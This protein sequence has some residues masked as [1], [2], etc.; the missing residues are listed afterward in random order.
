[1]DPNSA[2]TTAA[3]R[4]SLAAY[5]A[6]MGDVPT[7]G[8]L[9]VYSIFDGQVTPQAL[10][11]WFKQLGLDEALLPGAARPVDAFERTTTET[12]VSYSL[13]DPE[14][15]RG[16]KRE[17]GEEVATLMVRPVAADSERIVR[18]LVREVRHERAKTLK[19]ETRLAEIVFERDLSKD[20]DPGGGAMRI[21]PDPDAIGRLADNER[22]R[23]LEVISEIEYRYRHRRTYVS[24]DRLRSLVRKYTEGLNAVRVR[25][26]GGVYFVGHQ[27]A[28]TLA[29]LHE[30]V[31][32]FGEGSN[33]A[34][35]PLPDQEEM[36]E[37]VVS[38]WRERAREDLQRLSRDIAAARKSGASQGKIDELLR[39]FR[40]IRATAQE[41]SSLL[42]ETLEE[43]S[44]AMELAELQ[45]KD[46]VTRA[47]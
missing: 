47:D 15:T 4:D 33:F 34:R 27:H 37:M 1:M 14:R 30:L 23:V 35:V 5:E 26:T 10:E 2:D 29:A 16:R 8:Y 45:I 41:H 13:A 36:R 25:T 32:R 38:A 40:Q 21:D 6:A 9:V 7:L 42:S 28:A 46:L 18:H 24:G 44:G 31:A 12:S 22:G 43:T 39:R 19:Y 17:P 3:K 20:R 11:L